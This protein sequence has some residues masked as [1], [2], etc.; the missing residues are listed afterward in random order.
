MDRSACVSA[1]RRERF[2][3]V[4]VALFD[5]GVGRWPPETSPG[6]FAGGMNC[7]A[8]RFK[9]NLEEQKTRS[10]MHVLTCFHRCVCMC[11]HEHMYVC[12]YVCTYV[13]M[14]V[15]AYDYVCMYVYGCTYV[16][17]YVCMDGWMAGWLAGWLH[18]WMD[19]WMYPKS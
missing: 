14:Y 5:K 19:G 10:C 13:R 3:A 12:T 7:L 16:R 6:N 18:G 15:C 17:M 1:D 8:S 4:L 11:M 2:Q 9:P